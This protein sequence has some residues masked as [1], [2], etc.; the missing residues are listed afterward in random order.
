M[1]VFFTRGIHYLFGSPR[2]NKTYCKNGIIDCPIKKVQREFDGRINYEKND[3]IEE[4]LQTHFDTFNV[5]HR[6]VCCNFPIY[7]RRLFLK[8][9]LAHYKLWRRTIDLAGGEHHPSS[10]VCRPGWP[11]LESAPDYQLGTRAMHWVGAGSAG[12]IP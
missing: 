5:S 12:E 7:A 1:E 10:G 8:R 9:F 2:F 11:S 6:E 4:R 3:L